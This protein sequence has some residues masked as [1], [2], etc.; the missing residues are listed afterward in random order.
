M[1]RSGIPYRSQKPTFI[2]QLAVD[3]VVQERRYM[4]LTPAEKRHAAHGLS[5]RGLTIE[6]I[7]QVLRVSD[8]TVL[9][10]VAQDPPPILDVDEDGNYVDVE[11]QC[12]S[13]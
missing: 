12:V 13:V 10:L 11:G 9:R 2:D 6:Q 8:R 4:K 5:A 1:T 7:A 3:F